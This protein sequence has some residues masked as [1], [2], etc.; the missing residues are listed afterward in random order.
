METAIS[1]EEL[2]TQRGNIYGSYSAQVECV[3][4]IVMAMRYCADLN[5]NPPSAELIAEWHYLAIKIA[6]MAA[7]EKY[8]DSYKD[9]I[10]YTTLMMEERK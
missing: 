3:S 9:L 5:G 4:T 6:R 10:G 7:N 8:L 1:T 2:L